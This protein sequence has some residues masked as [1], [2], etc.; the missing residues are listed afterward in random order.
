MAEAPRFPR[1]V[2]LAILPNGQRLQASPAFAR[3]LD[4]FLTQTNVA[5]AA[6]DAASLAPVV[7]PFQAVNTGVSPIFHTAPARADLAPLARAC[8]PQKGLAPL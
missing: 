3:W 5:I 7:M 8:E 6:T 2:E 1:P 4:Q